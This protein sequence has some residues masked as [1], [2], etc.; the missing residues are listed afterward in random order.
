MADAGF[1]AGEDRPDAARMDAGFDAGPF[2]GGPEMTVTFPPRDF[3]C[4]AP[5]SAG[6]A[7]TVPLRS[8]TERT[9][10]V[11]RDMR[12][13]TLTYVIGTLSI[14]EA[15]SAGTAVGFNLDGLDSMEGSILIS[16]DCEEFNPDFASL[17]DP[18][19]VGV[20]NTFQGLVA[21]IESLLDASMCPGMTTD[22]CL[23]VTIQEQILDGTLLL[24]VEVTNIDSFAYDESVEVALYAGAV[25]GGGMPMLLGGGGLAPGQT[26]DTV[27]TLVAPTFGD[28]FDGRLRVR[29]TGMVTLLPG[30]SLLLPLQLDDPELRAD[31]STAG[32]ALGVMGGTTSIDYLVTAASALMPGIEDTLGAIFEGIADVTP[33]SDPVICANISSGYLLDAVPALRR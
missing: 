19:H 20:D 24:L 9:V 22:G 28:I 11:T 23:D 3:V 2:D 10:T 18:G 31:I 33:T 7:T 30:G 17:L 16:A 1:D 29:W 5:A 14:L 13:T 32:L 15:S 4:G 27:S 12:P 21:T 8:V 25:P 26:F 6:C